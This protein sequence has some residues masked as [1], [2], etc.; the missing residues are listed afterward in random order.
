MLTCCFLVSLASRL[1]LA[2]LEDWRNR[3]CMGA[4]ST[5]Q[6]YDRFVI[7]AWHARFR[8][9]GL[10]KSW[11]KCKTWREKLKKARE[12]CLRVEKPSEL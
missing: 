7:L 9:A 11:M 5:E 6:D 12:L 2:I 1:K 8:R 3:R 10:L 4:R